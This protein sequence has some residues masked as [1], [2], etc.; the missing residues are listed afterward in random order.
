MRNF[1][2][3]YGRTIL[4]VGY[5]IGAGVFIMSP[6]P[7]LRPEPMLRL[8]WGIA[9]AHAKKE[10]PKEPTPS[11]DVLKT[12][13]ASGSEITAKA[14]QPT[15][16]ADSHRSPSTAEANQKPKEDNEPS[17]P[18]VKSSKA[19]AEGDGQDLPRTLHGLLKQWFS[20]APP[21]AT[22]LPMRRNDLAAGTKATKGDPAPDATKVA[23]PVISPKALA[24]R[25]AA[26]LALRLAWSGH[27]QILARNLTAATLEKAVALGMKAESS[28]NIGLLGDSVT[29]LN[30]PQSMDIFQALVALQ[31]IAPDATLYVNQ[32]YRLHPQSNEDG[33]SARPSHEAA[34]PIG[35]CSP[36]RCY[37][38]T[39]IGWQ[40]DLRVC[41]RDL[42]IG[43]IDTGI[44]GSHPALSREPE[45]INYGT[46]GPEKRVAGNDLH[47]TGVLAL[48]AGDPRSSTPGLIPRAKFYVADIFFADEKGLPVSTTMHLLEALDWMGRLQVQIVNLSL[49]GPKDDLVQMAIASM[50]QTR[51]IDGETRPGTIFVAAAGN[52]G[53]GAPPSYPAAY[54]EVLAVTAVGRNL[55]GYRR[56]NQGDY[57]DV[58]APG[59][60]IWTALPQGRQGFQTG[61]SFA[62]PYVTAVVASLYRTLPLGVRSKSAILQRIPIRDLGTPGP[63]RVYGRGLVNAPATCDGHWPKS[64]PVAS[65]GPVTKVSANP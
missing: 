30:I 36:E 48:L 20:S 3:S 55:S 38:A 62:A 27:T 24:R 18:N 37:G 40:D 19:G 16:T 53:P 22:S 2:Q 65:R 6:H 61:T 52:G 51:T 9:D 11:W 56:A 59:V 8:V 14:E 17:K 25:P 58:S 28:R 46:I 15:N 31:Q 43:V 49:S 35:G 26:D 50:S 34:K 63:D 44:D 23:A 45:R 13:V 47:G 41:A 29:Q 60:D 7:D 4:R 42:K 21:S 1:I 64:V 12:E 33:A 57:I 39:A 10:R 54:T 5:L 32:P